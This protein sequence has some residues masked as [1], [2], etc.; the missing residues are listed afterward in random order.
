MEIERK[1]DAIGLVNKYRQ[2]KRSDPETEDDVILEWTMDLF[3]RTQKRLE[4]RLTEFC[5][6]WGLF[7]T[8]CRVAIW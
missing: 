6:N 1:A 2:I 7:R 8:V 5:E 4:D 3:V